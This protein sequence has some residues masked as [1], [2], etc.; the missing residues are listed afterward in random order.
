MIK[1]KANRLYFQTKVN[2]LIESKDNIR[3]EGFVKLKQ[4]LKELNHEE[5]KEL[6]DLM[7]EYLIDCVNNYSEKPFNWVDDDVISILKINKTPMFKAKVIYTFS[8]TILELTAY[9][10]NSSANIVEIFENNAK[11]NNWDDSII[12]NFINKYLL[13]IRC[14]V[15]AF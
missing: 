6:K 11:E 5:F 15:A 12:E 13:R 4:N 3:E 1:K 10:N 14:M 7:S 8:S 9:F 2:S